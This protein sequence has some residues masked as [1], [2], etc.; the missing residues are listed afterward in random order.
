MVFAPRRSMPQTPR[1]DL[2]ARAQ[3]FSVRLLRV[4][5]VLFRDP[6]CSRRFV[7]GLAA[8]GTAIGQNLSEAQSSVSR[9]QMAQCYRVALRESREARH[10]LQI[11]R[12]LRKADAAEVAWLAGEA[13]EFIAMLVT[14]V[15]RLDAPR[16]TS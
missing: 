12:E 11:V 10:S 7:E 5:E 16:E 15:R 8:A 2:V 13:N 14:S 3:V 9:R 4:C 6:V 1:Q